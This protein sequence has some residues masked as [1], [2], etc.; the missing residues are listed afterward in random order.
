MPKSNTHNVVGEAVVI[1]AAVIGIYLFISLAS[2]APEDLDA[3]NGKVGNLGG[4]L[5]AT[6]AHALLYV[7]G[8]SSY[9][10]IVIV[11]SAMWIFVR[12]LREETFSWASALSSLSGMLLLLIT[13]SSIESLRV[14][15]DYA[16]LPGARGGGMLGFG[17]A[18]TLYDILGFHG[19]TLILI[20]LWFV[21]L[22]LFA[23]FSWI[24]V[25]ERIGDWIGYFWLKNKSGI[26]SV[27]KVFDGLFARPESERAQ[28][29]GRPNSERT[30]R[31]GPAVRK[32]PGRRTKPRGK[33]P[34]PS[35][36]PGAAL[37]KGASKPQSKGGKNAG[38]ES[39]EPPP[40]DLLSTAT[41]KVT[42][43]TDEELRQLA[44]LIEAKLAEFGV[45]AEVVEIHPGPVVTRYEIK[46]AT[47]V[48]GSQVINLVRDLSRALSVSSIRV[49]ETISG[50]TT[51]GL[52]VP[53][54]QRVTVT[55]QEVINSPRYMASNSPLSL[56]LGKDISGEVF[57]VDLADMPHLLVAGTTG[58]GKSV[59]INSMILSILYKSTPEDVRMILIDPKVVELAPFDN[60]PH[61]LSPVVT[62][63]GLVPA[64]LSWCVAEMER[65]YQLMARLG[66]R[67]LT[68]LNEAIEKGAIDPEG[69]G[70]LERQP[71]IV[72][73]VDELADL[74]AVAGKKVEQLISR[75]AQKARAAGIHLILATQRPSVDVITGLIKAN[76][77]S[78]IG[79]Q[80]S[81]RIDSRTILDQ[82]GAET[83]LGK[84]DMLYLPTGSPELIRVHGAFVSDEDVRKVTEHIRNTC[85]ETQKVDFSVQAASVTLDAN[86]TG[87][88]DP[89]F[90]QAVEIVLSS[91][92]IS[93]SL[94]QRNLRIGYNRAARL[95][96]DMERSGMI[97]P[98]DST[99]NRKVLVQGNDGG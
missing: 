50:K 13:T 3:G 58:S 54:A 70:E 64:V 90:D 62:D 72:V 61:L 79:F 2:Y 76:V 42:T 12:M 47:G 43:M 91:N 6:I 49:L 28:V 10:A 35:L 5:G 83:L 81:S 95:I 44:S 65:R 11:I 68:G 97:S 39:H 86:A 78:R 15:G 82:G 14:Y 46:P 37:E 56:A 27:T 98:M 96:E 60:L 74:M 94:V 80:V 45:K 77:P 25:C 89:L 73:I 16:D 93:I 19:S 26:M 21:S 57:V 36:S 22:S 84:G 31:S 40:V 38:E 55:L 33:S 63:M 67:N 9:L 53:N 59:Q 87:E 20:G 41:E 71:L 51:M 99:G 34:E 30:G 92:R 69:D 23:L 88:R 75:L 48:K 17:F 66:T 29:T 8:R 24:D 1:I 18:K 52:E 7:F 85:P 4:T 32:K